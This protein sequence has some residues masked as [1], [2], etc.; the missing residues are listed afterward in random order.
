MALSKNDDGEHTFI[1]RSALQVPSWKGEVRVAGTIAV[2][3]ARFVIPVDATLIELSATEDCYINFGDVTVDAT[4]TVATAGS[5]L[6]MA[7]V[8]II[9]VPEDS[10]GVPFTHLAFIRVSTSGIIQAEKLA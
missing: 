3:T 7:G 4:S 1:R 5:R 9:V 2:A 10:S 8:Q 6:F